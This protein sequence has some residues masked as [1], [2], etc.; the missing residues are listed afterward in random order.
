MKSS[1][2]LVIKFKMFKNSSKCLRF[3][4]LKSTIFV[5]FNA[6]SGLN[7]RW[8]DFYLSRVGFQENFSKICQNVSVFLAP[9]SKDENVFNNQNCFV[10][11][12][13]FEQIHSIRFHY[14]FEK[15]VKILLDFQKF[16]KISS[17]LSFLPK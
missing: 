3:Y 15:F 7:L 12:F 14:N 5:Y 11:L 9:Q 2:S 17:T 1:K 16:V 6:C 4:Y 13:I 8:R 10:V